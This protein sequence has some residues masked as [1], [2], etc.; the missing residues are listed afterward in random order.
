MTD[1]QLRHLV[2]AEVEDRIAE[3][4]EAADRLGPIFGAVAQLEAEKD[5]GVVS[6]GVAVVE[7]GDGAFA[8][9]AAELEQAPRALGYGDREHHLE[10]LPDLRPLRDVAQAIEIDV[11]AAVDG[12]QK[13]AATPSRS[14]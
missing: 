7:L 5:L 1:V 6:P 8:D 10:L 9:A 3:R 4:G 11:G 13:L 2:L 12:D 14:T